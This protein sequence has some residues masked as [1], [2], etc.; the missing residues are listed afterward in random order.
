WPGGRRVGAAEIAEQRAT[1][2]ATWHDA[3][4]M[5]SSAP[6]RLVRKTT[7]IA[8]L[9]SRRVQETPDREAFRYPV[10]DQ[11]RSMTW[12]QTS[13]RVKAIAGGL[14]A[15]GLQREERVGILCNTR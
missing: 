9:F 15:L 2:G 3:R 7:S 5:Q 13:E 12:R 1:P 10:G 8:Q 4:R 14:L 6:E 11:W